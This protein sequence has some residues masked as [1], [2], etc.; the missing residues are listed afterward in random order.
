MELTAVIGYIAG[1]CTTLAVIPQIVRAWR[2]KKVKDVSP[3]MFLVLISGVS[4]WVVYG[5]LKQDIPI[6]ATNGVS[7]MLNMSML[8]L[9]ARYKNK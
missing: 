3:R 6:I 8:Y 4:L 9:I 2:S 5:V 7:L 1:I